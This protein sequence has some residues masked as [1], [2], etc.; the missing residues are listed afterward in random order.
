MY[1]DLRKVYWSEG[2]KKGISQFVAKCPDCQ[3]VKVDHQRPGGL[4]QNIELPEWKWEMINMNF[5]TGLP[6]SHRQHD[7][8]WV[9]VYRMTK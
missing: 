4:A 1:R 2:M 8:I 6:S 5:I 7:F 3:Q 9:V